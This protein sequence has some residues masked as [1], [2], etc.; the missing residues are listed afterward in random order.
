MGW[1]VVVRMA[2]GESVRCGVFEPLLEIDWG[3]GI[4]WPT[5]M[6]FLEQAGRILE[7]RSGIPVE[8]FVPAGPPYAILEL[9]VPNPAGEYLF[10]CVF[11]VSI[12]Y[13]VVNWVSCPS[14]SLFES[15][16]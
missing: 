8:V 14:L 7:I 16:N 13:L 4:L 11:E 5:G 10:H 6:V 1:F 12:D 3:S 9:S 2:H 15:I